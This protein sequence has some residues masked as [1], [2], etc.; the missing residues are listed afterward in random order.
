[1]IWDERD[2]WVGPDPLHDRDRDE[3][4]YFDDDPHE[5]DR[6]ASR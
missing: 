6:M 5:L 2:G 4:D 1:M 3:D